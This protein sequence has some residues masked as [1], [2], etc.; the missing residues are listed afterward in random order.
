[1]FNKGEIMEHELPE[2]EDL[3]KKGKELLKQEKFQR[4]LAYFE[5]AILLAPISI[6]TYN[7]KAL[8]LL[9]LVRNEEVLVCLD[10][11][12]AHDPLIVWQT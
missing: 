2:V 10:Q 9:G 12:L 4:A 3:L 7:N 11:V 5:R 1:M 6:N 8:A